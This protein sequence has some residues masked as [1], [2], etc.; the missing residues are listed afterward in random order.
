LTDFV[1]ARIGTI[2]QP[3]FYNPPFVQYSEADRKFSNAMIAYWTNFAKFGNPNGNATD[4][5]PVWPRYRGEEGDVMGLGQDLGPTQI[6]IARLRFI[7]SLYTN[8]CLREE[9][10]DLCRNTM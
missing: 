4:H 2:D 5:L 1:P 9:W 7:D 3:L 8:G 6:Q 10:F